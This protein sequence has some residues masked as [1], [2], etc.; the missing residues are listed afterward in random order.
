MKAVV[1]LEVMWD[2]RNVTTSAGYKERAPR[3]FNI[4]PNNFTGRRLHSW[5][6]GREFLVTNACPQLVSS[7]KGRGT[8]DPE[9]LN[10]NLTDLHPYDLVLVC[11][12]VAQSTYKREAV[13]DARVIEMP[14][15]AARMWNKHGIA[16]VHSAVQG[17]SSV[18]VALKDKRFV[19]EP[20]PTL[21]LPIPSEPLQSCR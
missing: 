21:T 19:L 14:H 11:G 5:L 17:G 8:P 16:L 1:V 4:N 15:P 7:A 20:L 10:N 13:R 9:W 12:K 2:W 3:W 18:R 6:N